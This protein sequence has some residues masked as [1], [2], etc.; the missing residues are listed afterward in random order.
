M[1]KDP[2]I[3]SATSH[4]APRMVSNGVMLTDFQEVTASIERWEE[5]TSAWCKRAEVHEN[6][7][8]EALS[9]GYNLSAGEHLSRAAVYY[10]FS[11]FVSTTF[12]STS[13]CAFLIFFASCFSGVVI[14][15]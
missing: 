6:L 4:W 10:H 5:W 13:T 1:S 8:K 3:E 14:I 15:F 9:Q 2:R 7:G 12:K 11:K